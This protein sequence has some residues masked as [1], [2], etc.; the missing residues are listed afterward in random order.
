[1]NVV[2]DSHPRPAWEQFHRQ[3]GSSL[4]Q[5]W[6]YGQALQSLNVRIHRAAVQEGG[7]VVALAQFMVRRI[8]GYISLSSCTRGPVWHPQLPA[9]DRAQALRLL[10]KGL[11][12]PAW[13][14]T[15][16]SP[17]QPAGPEADAQTRGLWRVMTGYS[18]VM[19]DLTQPLAALRAGLDGKWR[20]RLVRAEADAGFSTRVE[21]NLPEARRLLERESQ[22]RAERRFQGLPTALVPAYIEA[23]TSREQGFAVS[24][25][26]ARKETQAALLFL[27]H[28]STATYHI[29]WSS[30]AGRK[31]NAHN[32]LMWRAIE[33]LQKLGLQRLDLGGVNTRALPGITRFKLGTGGQVLTLAGTYY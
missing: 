15:L 8:A 10:K 6:A 16:F 24:Y 19:L 21:P 3:H 31:A 7:E 32:L 12:V 23:A 9:A 20:N 22:Q 2:W 5:S 14:A 28:G 18:T 29:G 25:A 33:Y 13:R 30:D 17:D 1:M 4:Q 11:P 27:V 26:Q